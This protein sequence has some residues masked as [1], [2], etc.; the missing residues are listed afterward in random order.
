M[1]EMLINNERLGEP[2]VGTREEFSRILGPVLESMFKNDLFFDGTQEDYVD[3][4][5]ARN[6][7][8]ATEADLQALPG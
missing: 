8:A 2:H 6:L 1:S 5:L 3:Q 7:Q 4:V